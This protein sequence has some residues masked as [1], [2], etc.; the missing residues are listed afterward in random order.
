MST[1]QKQLFEDKPYVGPKSTPEY[2]RAWR[3]KNRDRDREKNRLRSQRH[4]HS[5]YMRRWRKKNR[6]KIA[7]S[8]RR[9]LL[10]KY[11]LTSADYERMVIAQQNNCAICRR[12]AT[13]LK[14][15]N[16]KTKYL[17][18][19]VDHCH[20]TGKVRSL[21]CNNCNAI[22]GHAKDSIQVLLAAV[23]YLK[24]NGVAEC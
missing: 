7:A 1:K 12:S 17:R 6:D 21:L 20:S 5:E 10:K 13:E 4:Y 16:S 11:G 15:R 19:D 14:P 9:R 24:A 8:D 3:A 23:E 22:L 18:L 2:Q